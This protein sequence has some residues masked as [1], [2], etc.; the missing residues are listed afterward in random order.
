[1]ADIVVQGRRMVPARAL[2]LGF[3]YA[4]PELDEALRS[5]LTQTLRGKRERTVPL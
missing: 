2:A 1:M 4:H 3:P 5:A